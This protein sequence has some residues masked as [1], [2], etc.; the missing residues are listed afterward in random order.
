MQQRTRRYVI[1]PQAILLEGRPQVQMEV[2]RTED[3]HGRI[4]CKGESSDLS[5]CLDCFKTCHDQSVCNPCV[6]DHDAPASA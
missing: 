5:P 2:R 6:V 4:L 3:R 1:E